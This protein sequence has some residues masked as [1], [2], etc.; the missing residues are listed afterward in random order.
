MWKNVGGHVTTDAVA[1]DAVAEAAAPYAVAALVAFIVYAIITILLI[2]A[3]N[4][5]RH[6]V[7]VVRTALLIMRSC[8]R[9]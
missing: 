9:D 3:N 1:A 5:I 6:R 7:R 2:V 8:F 4:D